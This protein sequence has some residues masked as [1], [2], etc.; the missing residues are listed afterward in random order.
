MPHAPSIMLRNGTGND[1]AFE[2]DLIP[3][4]V[5]QFRRTWAESNA[6]RTSS[7]RGTPS[8]RM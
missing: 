8:G 4:K 1:Q 5:D 6:I 3:T 7:G 2:V